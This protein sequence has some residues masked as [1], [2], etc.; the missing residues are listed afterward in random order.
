MSLFLF[1][2]IFAIVGNIY[3]FVIQ[4]QATTNPT[5]KTVKPV[6]IFYTIWFPT[7]YP[8]EWVKLRNLWYSV[9]NSPNVTTETKQKL[10]RILTLK[11]LHLSE[12]AKRIKNNYV[13][14]GMSQ[15]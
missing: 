5:E 10:L 4:V 12:G 15:Y 6:I 1:F 11:G 3:E 8:K 13:E 2:L 7:N 14:N 9:N